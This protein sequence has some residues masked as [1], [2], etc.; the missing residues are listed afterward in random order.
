VRSFS[1]SFHRGVV[2]PTRPWGRRWL[3]DY[4]AHPIE[5]G[6]IAVSVPPVVSCSGNV[7]HRLAP[8]YL[9]NLSNQIDAHST[10]P[11]EE[12][13]KAPNRLTGEQVTSI[14]NITEIRHN[15][16]LETG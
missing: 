15:G 13:T 16:K 10:Q 9:L 2:S 12:T 8:G 6:F 3:S 11:I 7:F 1:E 14:C 4:S 5:T